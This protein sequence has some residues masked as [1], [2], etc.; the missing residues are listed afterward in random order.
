LALYDADFVDIA[1]AWERCANSYRYDTISRQTAQQDEDVPGWSG[2]ARGV[3][4]GARELLNFIGFGVGFNGL[5]LWPIDET[6]SCWFWHWFFKSHQ[7]NNA[8]WL[9]IE[10]VCSIKLGAIEMKYIE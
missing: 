6:A 1:R 4:V 7:I 3:E 8:N 2:L 10:V 5:A 9:C